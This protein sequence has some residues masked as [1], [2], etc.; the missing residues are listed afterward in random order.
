VGAAAEQKVG[1]LIHRFADGRARRGENML[2]V[3]GMTRV[4]QTSDLRARGYTAAELA[5]LCGTG[6]LIH[7]RRGA[8]ADPDQQDGAI[9]EHQRLVLA[10]APL[11]SPHA[12]ISHDSAA[13]LHRLP[14]LGQ[15]PTRVIA[16]RPDAPG[17]KRRRLTEVRVA[18][19]GG[20]EVVTVD[21]IA[22]TS[23]ARTVVDMGRSRSFARTVVTGDAALRGGLEL[24][25]LESS[26]ELSRGRPGIGAARRAVRFLDERSES[27]GESWSRVQMHEHGVATPLLQYKVFDDY[28]RFVARCDF[29]WE[30]QRLLG[31]FDGLVKYAKLLR[32]GQSPSDVV[33]EEKMREDRLRELGWRVI[34]WVWADL[35]QPELLAGRLRR[36][37][38]LDRASA[39]CAW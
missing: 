1:V 18:A 23:L 2:K 36:A 35:Q 17:G 10:T 39:A 3:C 25:A 22:V 12:V 19:L 31:E 16:T 20:T 5:R 34:R 6:Q 29:C 28:G 27:A 21:G 26:L 24:A 14:L 7:V 13:V 33:V 9:A 32:P 8:Y 4:H 30:E 11:L 15:A 38:D 37:L